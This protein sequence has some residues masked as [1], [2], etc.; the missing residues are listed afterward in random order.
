[1]KYFSVA[2]GDLFEKKIGCF[3]DLPLAAIFAAGQAGQALTACTSGALATQTEINVAEIIK[4]NGGISEE[5]IQQRQGHKN[6][7]S[8]QFSGVWFGLWKGLC[9][10]MLVHIFLENFVCTYSFSRKKAEKRSPKMLDFQVWEGQKVLKLLDPGKFRGESSYPDAALRDKK[11]TFQK[12]V[13]H[14][15]LMLRSFQIYISIRL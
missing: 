2:T 8:S 7:I 6:D 1:M 5:S 3:W 11:D 12:K 9:I 4:I 13:I 14:V 10:A 15:Q